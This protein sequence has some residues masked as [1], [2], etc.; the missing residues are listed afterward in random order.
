MRWL[1]DYGENCIAESIN[2]LK[3]IMKKLMAFL[4]SFLLLAGA[5]AQASHSAKKETAQ[6]AMTKNATGLPP[7]NTLDKHKGEQRLFMKASSTA[8]SPALKPRVVPTSGKKKN[9]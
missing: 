3:K 5:K 6:P 2:C 9:R 8:T 1:V 7:G 4:G